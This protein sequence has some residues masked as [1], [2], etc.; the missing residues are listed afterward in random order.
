MILLSIKKC[1]ILL[2]LSLTYVRVEWSLSF[3]FYHYR[4]VEELLS[5][6]TWGW[7]GG[8]QSMACD[9]LSMLLFLSSL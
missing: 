3:L 1:F 5:V 8:G 9:L 7:G 6:S 2:F 4:M